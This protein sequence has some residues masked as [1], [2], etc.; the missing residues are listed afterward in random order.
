MN[1]THFNLTETDIKAL[2]YAL[3]IMSAYGFAKSDREAEISFALSSSA[4]QKLI[5]RKPLSDREVYF[6]SLA[7]DCAFKALRDEISLDSEYR[8]GL[9][10]YMFT[11]NKLHPIFAPF[12]N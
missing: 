4:G 9:F 6:V 2:T 1:N 7:V 10:P 8:S 5:L 12:L 3:E 11:I